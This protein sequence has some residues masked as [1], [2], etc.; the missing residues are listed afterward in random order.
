[1]KFAAAF[2]LICLAAPALS[3][4]PPTY[5][6]VTDVAADDTLNVRAGPSAT[7]PDIG[8]LPPDAGNLILLSVVRRRTHAMAVLSCCRRPKN[9]L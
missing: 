2:A 5:W 1:M 3:D 9:A 4:S 6:R 8:D 7:S